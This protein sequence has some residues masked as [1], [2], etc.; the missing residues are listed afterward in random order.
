MID[1]FLKFPDETTAEAL[2]FKVGPLDLNGFPLRVFNF[3]GSVDVIG[4]IYKPTGT[5]LEN[6]M[7]NYPEMAPIDGW[8]VNI[9][10]DATIAELD[11]YALTPN[12]PYR[13]WA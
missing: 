12:A 8:H 7:G 10:T 13:V 9:R 5:I 2:L 3:N 6:D 4:T 11:A 1:Y